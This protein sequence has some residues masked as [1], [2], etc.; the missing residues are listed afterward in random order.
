MFAFFGLESAL[1]VSGEVKQPARPVPRAIGI[2][3]TAVGL[4]YIAVQLVAQ[5]VLGSALASPETARA[6]LAAAAERF[7]GAPGALLIL[8]GMVI[9]TF[10]FET[11]GM[12]SAPRTLFAFA[13]DGYLPRPVARV[14]GVFRTPHI[15]IVVQ[16]VVAAG[17]ALSGT[18]V[19]LAKISNVAILL[20]YLACCI[21]AWR[22]R[23]LDARTEGEPFRMPGGAVVPWVA[24]LLVGALLWNAK[25]EEWLPTLA[26]IGLALVAYLIRRAPVR[27]S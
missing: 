12:L 14:H 2:A 5:G 24:A 20:V 19:M 13:T 9:S 6:P 4:L 26:V 22:L 21:G 1:Q 17:L 15:A 18:Y 3:V 11:A 8:T 25:W 10:G 27:E 7:A 23:R 16:A